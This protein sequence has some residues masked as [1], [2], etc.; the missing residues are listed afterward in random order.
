MNLLLDTHILLWSQLEPDKLGTNARALLDDTDTGIWLSP[1]SCW[2]TLLLADKGRIILSP[3]PEEWLRHALSTIALKQAPLN[4]EVAIRSR[5]IAL[6]HQD[7]AD[8]FLIA[9][10]LVYDLT[11]MTAD[12]RILNSQACKLIAA[13]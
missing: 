10:A 12:D 1:I 8:R 7:P 6:P 3:S 11:L 2:E 9:T 5:S 13:A 4:N